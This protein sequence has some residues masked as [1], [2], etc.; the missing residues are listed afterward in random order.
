MRYPILSRGVQIAA[1]V[2][3]ISAAR[4]AEWSAGA[5]LSDKDLSP[6]TI[7]SNF[8][9]GS[10]GEIIE[11]S[12]GFLR[13][14]TRHWVQSSGRNDQRY[15]FYFRLDGVDNR[16]VTVELTDIY[17]L[18]RGRPHRSIF[19][20]KTRP[21]VSYDRKSWERIEQTDLD[22]ATGTWRWRH[23]FKSSPA[24]VAYAHPYPLEQAIRW[25]E[26]ISRNP[27]VRR[28]GIGESVDG[29]PLWLLT[30]GP[31]RPEK[32]VLLTSLAHP[33]EDAAGYFVEGLVSFLLSDDPQAQSIRRRLLFK[34]IPVMNPDGLYRGHAR[35]NAHMED[36]NSAWDVAKRDDEGEPE[37][38]A[39]RTWLTAWTACRALDF[40]FDIHCNGQSRTNHGL[41]T[42]DS[43]LRERLFP[44]LQKSFPCRS[45]QTKFVGSSA[46][47]TAARFGSHSATIELSQGR[48][49]EDGARYLTIDDYRAHG[50]AFLRALDD[51]L[52][53]PAAD[54]VSQS[55]CVGAGGEIVDTVTRHLDRAERNMQ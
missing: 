7:T 32:T 1:L 41:I 39:V 4:C 23:Y 2:A 25:L 27:G 15:W 21:V 13:G 31:E 38:V 46:L 36:L 42:P 8:D 33:G 11:I 55:P 37:I 45:T 5:N 17:G 35:L 54:A 6:I 19:D 29:R 44:L 12:P 43:V 40:H 47:Y 50:G 53:L 18:Y 14:R 26:D 49:G 22:P 10:I 34:I 24:W 52:A 3:V 16:E 9:R 28:E 48:H 20:P 51:F 30:I